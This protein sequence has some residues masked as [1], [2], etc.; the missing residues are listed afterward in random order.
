MSSTPVTE[1]KPKR[2]AAE[3]AT[4]TLKAILEQEPP[5]DRE[6]AVAKVKSKRAPKRDVTFLG[7][8][9]KCVYA[10]EDSQLIEDEEK[11]VR[12]IFVDVEVRGTPDWP[13]H[14]LTPAAVAAR[15]R[16]DQ[17]GKRLQRRGCRLQ[18]RCVLLLR[19]GSMP[20]KPDR[21]CSQA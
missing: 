8:L 20:R 7:D 21:A 17:E 16:L 4:E 12:S 5:A 15:F 10:S 6:A 9:F 1:Q 2:K 13:V 11:D 3:A 14:S 18:C 19:Y